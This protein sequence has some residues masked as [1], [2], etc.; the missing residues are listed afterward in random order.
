MPT[1][2]K[3]ARRFV[4][5]MVLTFVAVTLVV[6][7]WFIASMFQ[8]PD[9][10]VAS[11]EPPP[12]RPVVVEVTR[13]D[14]VES[15]TAGAEAVMKEAR[16]ISIPLGAD[17]QVVTGL[18]VHASELMLPGSVVTWVNGH[19]TFALEGA[20]P[21][22]RDLVIGDSG[23]DVRMLQEGLSSW[24][25]DL[26]AD[27]SFGNATAACVTALYRGVGSEPSMRNVVDTAEVYE[28]S[29][30]VTERD[31]QGPNQQ[32]QASPVRQEV[33]VK[34]SDFLIS[35]RLPVQVLSV[36]A[37]GTELSVDNA[38]VGVSGR[39]AALEAEVPSSIAADLF[40][41]MAAE[42]EVAG[43]ILPVRIVSINA[44]AEEN[45]LNGTAAQG[46]QT[47][48]SVVAFE[49]S[50]G[51]IPTAWVGERVLVTINLAEPIIDVLLVPQRAVA[52]APSGQTSVLV[53]SSDGEF[54]QVFVEELGCSQ[55]M[56]AISGSGVDEGAFVRVD[57]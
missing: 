45:S 40:T 42:A 51:Q 1:G 52:A 44:S 24:G 15:T 3:K 35:V 38:K 32:S 16:D 7:T 49:R 4:I 34:R 27:G 25:C 8:S 23:P 29:P 17:L 31:G 20:F 47:S 43:E 18:G 33:Q 6:G 22:Y 53:Q 48:S 50:D 9:Q 55:G 41:G 37:V 14:L 57:R 56:C 5:G 30:T 26:V 2:S 12:P 39:S 36:P 54:V 21:L 28:D 19:P 11:A 10:R 13:G 46:G